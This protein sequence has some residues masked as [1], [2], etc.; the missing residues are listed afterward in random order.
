MFKGKE[1]RTFVCYLLNVLEYT[2]THV[3]LY[4]YCVGS[5]LILIDTGTHPIFTFFLLVEDCS[6]FFFLSSVVFTILYVNFLP[7]LIEHTNYYIQYNL[8]HESEL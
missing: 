5:E 6:S 4:S 2:I 7:V 3:Q 8:S 1:E